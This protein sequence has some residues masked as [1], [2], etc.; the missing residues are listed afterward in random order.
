[1]PS[2]VDDETIA[3]L[4]EGHLDVS[5][6]H[7]VTLHL[8]SCE[9]CRGV[10]AAAVRSLDPVKDTVGRYIILDCIGAGAMGI[11]YTA[12]DPDLGRKVALKLL[13]LDPAVASSNDAHTRLLREAQAMAQL[14]HPNV[15]TIYDVGTRGDEVFLAMELVDGGTL[16][17]WMRVP[18]RSWRDV[19]VVFRKAGEGLAAAHRAGLVHRDFKPD[20]VLVGKDG[21]VRVTDFGL[22]RFAAVDAP[23]SQPAL[24]GAPAALATSMT[25]AG[26]LVG[27]PAYMAPE[28]LSGQPADARSDLFGFCVAL[29][30]ALHGERPFAGSSLVELKAAI[31]RGDVRRPQTARARRIPAW[32]LRIVESGLRASPGKRPASMQ[33]LLDA[34][35][36]GLS[37]TRF[38]RGATAAALV[39]TGCVALALAVPRA[40]GASQPPLVASAPPGPTA[41]SD[42]PRPVSTSAEAVD[43]YERGL[44]KLRD[45]DWSASDFRRATEL[46]PVLAAAHLRFA[47]TDFWE[48]PIEARQHLASAVDER[49]HLGERDQLLLRAAQAWIQS[50]PADHA[51]YARLADEAL[52]R[53]PLDAELAYFAGQARAEDGD[54]AGAVER[55]DRAI[56]LDPAFGAAYRAKSDLLAFRGDTE[57][58]LGA[59]D[60]CMQHAPSAKVCIAERTL[61]EERDGK[62]LELEEDAQ[63]LI[64]QDPSG[65]DSYWMLALASYAEGRPV[66]GVREILRQRVERVSPALKPRF[67]LAH[68]WSL[69]VLTGAF[70]AANDRATELE[71]SIASYA[72]RRL[73]ARAALWWTGTLLESGRPV[74]AARR[75][76]DFLDREDAWVAE[77]RADDFA[78]LRDPTPRL[79]LAE[80]RGGLLSAADFE[81]RRAAWVAAWEQK[82]PAAMRPFVWLHGFATAIET[83]EDA[84]RALA[85]QPAYGPIPTFTP[86]MLGDAYVGRAFFLAG[87]TAEALPYLER[88][89][90]SCLAV[91]SPFE[92][93]QIQ[94]TLGQAL[95]RVG[96]HDEACAAYGVVQSRWG[97]ARPRSVTAEKARAL[98]AAEG[99]RKGP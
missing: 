58:A 42:L 43:A 29:F 95:A 79:L 36:A 40:H 81:A 26:T 38:V 51:S 61:I 91:E 52:A 5:R 71:R 41:M 45:G 76:R 96:R 82:V 9:G 11:V 80:R 31:E 50:Q 73:H 67:E 30:E 54:R 49:S 21:G 10:L 59:L 88:A 69:D 22:A 77:P 78:M 84:E 4:I 89:A 20:N 18:D 23:A 2:C 37:R 44:T 53:Y 75:A 1:M 62:C 14:S 60:A 13:R 16:T 72:D 48:Y 7:E 47:V 57:G 85:E 56:G 98:S 68:L 83:R 3:E 46:D 39:G 32:L 25:G 66:E 94:L 97:A 6:G 33:T 90:R 70:G 93:T 99:C 15:I 12:Q 34:L 63:R 19:L 64:A 27:T 92:H 8:D 86:Y 35:D 74:E 55:F 87:R 28:Q 24:D 65:D 17:D